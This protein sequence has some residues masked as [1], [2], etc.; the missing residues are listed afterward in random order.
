[1]AN[2]KINKKTVTG[3]TSP[4]SLFKTVIVFPAY[5]HIELLIDA[6]SIS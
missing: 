6:I 5:C 2:K 4:S 3:I 1:M